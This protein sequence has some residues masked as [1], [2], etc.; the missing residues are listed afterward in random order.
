MTATI[1]VPGARF[2]VPSPSGNQILVISD[3][4][5]TVT[6][7]APALISTGNALTAVT[8]VQYF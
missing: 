8:T 2:I 5:D 1:P 3:S 7:L 4:A 6:V